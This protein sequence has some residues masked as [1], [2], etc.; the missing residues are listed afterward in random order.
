MQNRQIKLRKQLLLKVKKH[1]IELKS[2]T[3]ITIDESTWY[4]KGGKSSTWLEIHL[5][6]W[7]QTEVYSIFLCSDISG[8]I[9]QGIFIIGV[10]AAAFPV[11]D[12]PGYKTEKAS[13]WRRKAAQQTESVLCFL[14][15]LRWRKAVS[16]SAH[17]LLLFI[18]THIWM[19]T[20]SGTWENS[21]ITFFSF[22][23][24]T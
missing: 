8:Q 3:C 2:K 21:S 1:L 19:I 17:I 13:M 16:L 6:R 22:F 23:F 5:C 9:F 20:E 4:L 18:E 10:L 7:S 12:L 14:Q 15:Y 11:G 24:L